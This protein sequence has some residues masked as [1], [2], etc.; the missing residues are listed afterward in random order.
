MLS[1]IGPADELRRHGIDP[2]VDLPVG[3]NLH[4]HVFTVVSVRG[5]SDA[6]LG[7]PVP[8]A[9]AALFCRAGQ[10]RSAVVPD[11]QFIVTPDVLGAEAS[12]GESPARGWTLLPTLTQPHSRGSIRLRD[13]DPLSAPLI[14]PN[15]LGHPRDRQLLRSGLEIAQEI[16]AQSPLRELAAEQVEPAGPLSSVAAVDAHIDRTLTTIFHPVGTCRMGRDTD[17][18]VDPSLRVH[19]LSGLSVADASIMPVI[20]SGNTNAPAIMI[21]ERA[22]ELLLSSARSQPPAAA[23]EGSVS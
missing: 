17:A 19:G 22:V 10:S 14:E 2:V 8:L 7:S 4:D 6:G 12:P 15:Y 1:G 9:E 21:G 16:A 5:R 11:L 20:T 3:R 18:V 13:A 23:R